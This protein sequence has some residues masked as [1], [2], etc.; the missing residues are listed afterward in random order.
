MFTENPVLI[1][2]AAVLLALLALFLWWQDFGLRTTRYTVTSERLPSGFDGFRIL[3][4]SDYHNSRPLE[5]K[6]VSTVM[7]ETPDMI[8]FTGDLADSRH[9]DIP[10]ALKLAERTAPAA[11]AY[12]VSGNHEARLEQYPFV[13]E[14][15]MSYGI[16]VLEDSKTVIRRGDDA[17]TLIGLRDPRFYGLEGG[18]RSEGKH[19]KSGYL[20]ISRMEALMKGEEGFTVIAAHRPEFLPEYSRAGADLVFTGHSHGG[21]FS[22]PFTDIGVFVPNQG[23]FPKYAAGLKEERGTVEIISRGLGNSAFPFR[24]FNRPEIIIVT[25]KKS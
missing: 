21:Q 14:K 4:I 20:Y 7:G 2:I 3:Q 23:L 16:R 18:E 24:L 17:I 6:I 12:Y 8:L 11:P 22:I 15:L 19:T 13:R 25:L 9:T 10:A 1:P 5:E